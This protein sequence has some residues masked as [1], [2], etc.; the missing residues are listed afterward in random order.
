MD[1]G[2]AVLVEDSTSDADEDD[3]VS[4]QLY[5]T[6]AQYGIL[7]VGMMFN[8]AQVSKIWPGPLYG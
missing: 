7:N 3:V 1:D 6:V 4:C 2:G 5:S 8:D